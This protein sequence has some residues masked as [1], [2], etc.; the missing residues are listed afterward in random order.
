MEHV[1]SVQGDS[2]L[3]RS[4]IVE[5]VSARKG[6][7]IAQERERVA[8][9][10]KGGLLAG[11]SHQLDCRF[12]EAAPGWITLTISSTG[13]RAVQAESDIVRGLGA[14]AAAQFRLV[15]KIRECA[16]SG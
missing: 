15:R 8:A 11:Q 2:A 16:K 5:V 13:Q 1:F 9:T 3:V 7:V 14:I 6:L 10:F 4:R 12:A